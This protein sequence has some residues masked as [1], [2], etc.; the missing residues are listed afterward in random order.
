MKRQFLLLILIIVSSCGK[1]DS[2][3]SPASTKAELILPAQN[4][5]CING[6]TGAGISPNV[7]ITF[8]WSAVDKADSYEVNVKNLLNSSVKTVTV[9][10]AT[11]EKILLLPGVPYSWYTKR[12]LE[13]L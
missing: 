7:L 6:E 1:K 10:A 8:S 13:I 2:A 3:P 5:L 12:Y 4:S 9:K 11:Q